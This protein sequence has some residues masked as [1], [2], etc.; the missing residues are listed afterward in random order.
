MLIFA[1]PASHL[2]A[3]AEK[4]RYST[5]QN[6]PHDQ[7]YRQFLSR[8][9]NPL[10][11]RLGKGTLTGIDF[12]CGPGPT[13]SIMLEEMGYEM[14]LYDPYFAKDDSALSKQYD[15]VTCTETIEHFYTPR[16]EWL[17]MLNLLKPD[18]LL[19]IMTKLTN[20]IESFAQ[21]YYKNDLTHVSFFSRETFRCLAD[22]DGLQVEFPADDVII[23]K[24]ASNSAAIP[25]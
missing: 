9:A 6:K 2:S 23:F 4:A 8:L 22:K 11:E 5:H 21:W 12:G 10:V 20:G 1:D 13:L 7:K 17:L 3:E 19:A 15:F 25:L 24:T 16:K 18:G 14:S